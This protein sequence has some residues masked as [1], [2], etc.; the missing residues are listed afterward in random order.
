[1][2]SKKYVVPAGVLCLLA[3]LVLGMKLG[4]ADDTMTSLKKLEDAFLVIK[5]A[6]V[7]D[8]DAVQLAENAIAGMLKELDPH[9]HYFDPKAMAGVNE[10]FNAAYEGVG[11][12][13]EFVEGIGGRD[14]VSV[15]TV[16]PG[17]PSDEAGLMSGDRIVRVDDRDAVGFTDDDV[18][19]SLRGPRGTTVRVEVL[20]PLYPDTLRFAIVR[21]RIPLYTSDAGYMVDERTGYIRINRFARTTYDEFMADLTALKRQGMQRLILDLRGNGGGYMDMAVRMADEFLGGAELIVSQRGRTAN[22]EAVFHSR[23]GGAFTDGPVMVLVDGESAS[24]SEIVAGALQDHDRALVVGQRTFGKGLVQ[25]Q[26]P[27]TDGSVLRLTV[28]RYYTPSGRLIQTP[29][30]HAD[31]EAYYEAKLSQ[32]RDDAALGLDELLLHVPDSL[33]FTTAGGRT[34]IGGGGILPD[35]LVYGDTLSPFMRFVV[36]GSH[37]TAFVRGWLDAHGAELRTAWGDRRDAFLRDYRVGDDVVAAFMAYLRDHGVEIVDAEPD[38]DDA[39]RFTHD[40]IAADR[41]LLEV[42]L[43]GRIAT[44]LFDRKAWY[45]VYNR[46]DPVFRQAMTLWEPA[47]AM[48]RR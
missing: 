25:Q 7:E 10:D 36:R 32:R 17:G 26:F 21:D 3:G 19:R 14:T 34:V 20:R 44:R 6:Y 1:M 31:L 13:F 33:K 2:M 9:S 48:A 22:T 39:R 15:Q 41:E 11:I 28:A 29:Y 12:A 35:F 46:Y 42:L 45:P 24:A 30:D 47:E 38:G 16:N 43:K 40:E 4:A 18:R 5:R 23:P 27:L 8:P 37:E